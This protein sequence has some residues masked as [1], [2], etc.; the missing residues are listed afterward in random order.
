[1]KRHKTTYEELIGK[2]K[3]ESYAKEASYVRDLMEKGIVSPILNSGTNGKKPAM[4]KR[5]WL[6][7]EET[8]DPDRIDEIKYGLSPLIS[9]DYYLKNPDVYERERK[10]VLSLSSFLSSRR[11]EL[12]V[13]VS[14]N[15][16]S[17]AIWKREKFLSGHCGESAKEGIRA[18]ELLRHC[19]I[20]MELLNTYHTA[21]PMA[22]YVRTKTEPQNILILENLDP[23]YGMRNVL[24]SGQQEL[25]GIGI[26]TLV[27]GGGKRV[28]SF[29][30]DFDI[31]AES[32]L[33]N[34]ENHFYY[35]G[36]LD[37]EGIGIYENF[38]EKLSKVIQVE[39]F[40]PAYQALLRDAQMEELPVSKEGQN[41]RIKSLFLDYFPTEQR[42]QILKI[43]EAGKYIPQEKLSV[44][45]YYTR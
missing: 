30:E 11:G 24:M 15:E 44:R 25:F 2:R 41:R 21:E 26:G 4:Y 32:Y 16:R 17:Y 5:Y 18:S 9:T 20:G 37:Y 38:A 22:V 43:L 3:F 34:P 39:P 14:E 40:V 8:A 13:A 42:R 23:F 6:F 1:M 28:S 35:F 29:F 33:K 27:Y 7:E 19:G 10:F 45:D 31:F 12:S 36:D